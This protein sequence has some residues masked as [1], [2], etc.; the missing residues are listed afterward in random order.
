[1]LHLD[2]SNDP[3]YLLNIIPILSLNYSYKI[4]SQSKSLYKY[5]PASHYDYYGCT[6]PNGNI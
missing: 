5:N 1:M 2:A 3:V 6:F 4:I